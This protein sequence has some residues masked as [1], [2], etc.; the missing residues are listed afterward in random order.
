MKNRL[1]V[2]F[3]YC[4]ENYPNQ[5]SAN[6]TKISLIAK[7]LVSLGANVS[8]INNPYYAEE[9]EGLHVLNGV[10]II[11]LPNAKLLRRSNKLSSILSDL[12]VVE[13]KNVV[14]LSCG[15]FQDH[16]STFLIAKKYG[17]SV[18]Y[19]FQEWHWDLE[20]NWKGKVNALLNDTFMLSFYDFIL[21]IS[22][23]LIKK[24]Y[25][26]NRELFKLP[27]VAEYNDNIGEDET[28]GKGYFLYC[29]SVNYEKVLDF[30]VQSYCMYKGN[31]KLKIVLSGNKDKIISFKEKISNNKRIEVYTKLPYEVLWNM[32]R[33][34]DALLIPLIPNYIP[35]VARFSQKTAEYF[36][37]KRPILTTSV[38]EMRTYFVDKKT[39]IFSDYDTKDYSSKMEWISSNSKEAE[40]IAKQGYEFAKEHF[41]VYKVSKEL[42]EYLL[43]I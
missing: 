25:K 28:V 3:V 26:Y 32:Y 31:S 5:F 24:S 15:K 1:N 14:I 7:S 33:N 39:V 19:I 4:T 37:A 27:I 12:Y 2:V 6:N 22:E 43:K 13:S 10:N 34:S 38:G 42:Y 17:F 11:D 41:D 16:I 8:L 30:V 9:V 35:D 18:G 29:A 36:S 21:P 40:F 20:D 23:F